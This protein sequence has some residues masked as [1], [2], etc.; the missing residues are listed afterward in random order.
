MVIRKY[1]NISSIRYLLIGLLLQIVSW[2]PEVV[3]DRVYA[4][5]VG[6]PSTMIEAIEYDYRSGV[7]TIDEWVINTIQA[8]KTP[9]K[10][11]DT[12]PLLSTAEKLKADR[13]ASMVLREI[14]DKFDEL[15][16]S[17][18]VLFQAALTRFDTDSTFDSPGGFFKLHYNISADSNSVP[19]VD[20]DLNGVPDYIEKIAAYCDTTHLR[21]LEM[22]YLEPLPDGGL[23]GDNKF[24]IY[25]QE[26]GVYGYTIP[27]GDGPEPWND[28]YGYIVLN[29]DFL[30]FAPNQDPEGSQYGAAKVTVAHEYRHAVQYAYDAGEDRW[31]SESD[32]VFTEEMVFDLSNDCYNYL[33]Q[34]FLYPQKSLME[35]SNHYY[36]CF[37][38]QLYLAQKFDTSLILA[39][40]EGAI[41]SPTVFDALSDSITGRYG[42][43]IDSAFSEFAVWN[44]CTNTRDDGLHYEEAS[45]YPAVAVGVSH[46][47]YPVPVQNSPSN[48]SG[49]GTSYVQFFPGADTGSLQVTFNGS[50]SREWSAWLILSTDENSH[51]FLPLTLTPGSYQGSLVVQHFESYYR[52]TLLGSNLTEFSSSVSFTYRAEVSPPYELSSEVMTTDS[53]VYSGGHRDF[54]Y[55]VINVAPIYDVVDIVVW[56]ENGWTPSDTIEYAMPPGLDTVF[57]IDIHP[58]VWTPIGDTST[59]FFSVHSRGDS[60]EVDTQSVIGFTVLQYGDLDF[61]G[62]IDI[63][64]LVYFTDYMFNGGPAPIP[65][66]EA[67]DWLCDVDIDISDLV[68]MVEYMFTSGSPPPCNPY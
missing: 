42:W 12:Y 44:Y 40:W 61:S 33:D 59:L 46:Y 65:V 68:S 39:G 62:A 9:Q 58:P 27:E 25:F 64:D 67:G 24:D 10:M 45:G 16:P 51:Q 56:D 32:A 53:V 49:Y 23:G 36:S 54:L 13:C 21:L 31:I 34:F 19:V 17:T 20:S 22:G 29:N 66:L 28:K 8:I 7:I 1:K 15:A 11:A 50:D 37:V 43:T 38:W 60:T 30:G 2:S 48:P 55:R 63:S 57:A 3:T 35:N 41:Y 5:S 26:M 47:N 14:I 52:V 4:A 6:Q 18:Q